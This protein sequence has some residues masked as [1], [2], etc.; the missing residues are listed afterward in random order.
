MDRPWQRREIDDS[1]SKRL[2]SELNLHAATADCLVGRGLDDVARAGGFLAPRLADLRPPVG[3]AGFPEAVQRLRLAVEQGET[4]GIFGD[5][6]VDGVTAAALLT[7]FLRSLGADPVTR[8]ARRDAGYGFGEADAL[9]FADRGCRLVVTV[10]CGTSDVAAILA[11]RARGLDTI[12]VDHHQ[13]P[14]RAD[15]P[16]FALLNPHRPDSRYPFRGLASV[17]LGFFLAAA[18]RTALREAGWF[19]SRAQPDV[20]R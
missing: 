10:D 8:V 15:H 18:L 9:F 13:V 5:Y 16:A 6:D 1:A 12:V 20:R 17:G 11:A 2:A 3:M 4:I 7:S 19:G 14:D